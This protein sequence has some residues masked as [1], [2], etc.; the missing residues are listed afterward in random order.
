MLYVFHS[1]S[2]VDKLSCDE[3]GF[4][5]IKVTGLH[6]TGR[7]DSDPIFQSKTQSGWGYTTTPLKFNND[8]LMESSVSFVRDCN[9]RVRCWRCS[10]PGLHSYSRY[11]KSDQVWA[12]SAIEAKEHVVS[13]VN[14]FLSRQWQYYYSLSKASIVD[15][16]RSIDGFHFSV[17]RSWFWR[18][19][20]F[21]DSTIKGDI[22]IISSLMFNR[23]HER[24]GS[25][26][27]KM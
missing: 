22:G 3:P 16:S 25:I 21:N 19:T 4:T 12:C 5:Y 24:I 7:H 20:R 26:E 27:W 9:I 11:R 8:T 15:V 6:T 10:F 18:D 1:Y 23:G 13:F 14:W 2:T 17:E